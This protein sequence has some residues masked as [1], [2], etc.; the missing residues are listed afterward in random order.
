MR[1][2]PVSLEHV[3][4]VQHDHTEQLN[5]CPSRK[6]QLTAQT[7]VNLGQPI[8]VIPVYK[9]KLGIPVLGS[10]PSR[11]SR[12]N[13][14]TRATEAWSLSANTT[15]SGVQVVGVARLH[16]AKHLASS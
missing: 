9:L 1:L 10:V 5:A 15:S 16:R 3:Q 6:E 14:T 7:A 2:G 8:T 11:Q 12:C 4:H 13:R